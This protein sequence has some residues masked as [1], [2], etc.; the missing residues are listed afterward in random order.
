[1]GEAELAPTFLCAKDLSRREK[2]GGWLPSPLLSLCRAGPRA[3]SRAWEAARPGLD[4][5]L[6]LS[7]WLNM[8]N[9]L[10]FPES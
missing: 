3:E 8:D 7:S 1:M 6:S 9:S 4:P 10:N 2:G 5:G